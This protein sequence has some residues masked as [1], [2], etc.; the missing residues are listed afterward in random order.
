[1]S[2]LIKLI[3]D[4]WNYVLFS[5]FQGEYEGNEFLFTNAKQVSH[6]DDNVDDEKD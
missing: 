6:D 4:S 5:A 3:E 2:L 1:M